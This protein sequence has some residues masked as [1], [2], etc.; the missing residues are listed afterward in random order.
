MFNLL[1]RTWINKQD[2]NKIIPIAFDMEWPFS[3]Q[4]GSKKTA[5]VQLCADINVC[6][7]FHLTN[8]KQL[9]KSLCVLLKHDRVQLHGI[10]IKK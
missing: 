2:P 5:V 3:Y 1:Y 9:P 10:N 7:V 4:T 8:V 6:Y